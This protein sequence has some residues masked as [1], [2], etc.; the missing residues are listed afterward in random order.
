[1]KFKNKF[2]YVFV[3]AFLKKIYFSEANSKLQINKSQLGERKTAV[4]KIKLQQHIDL[5][6]FNVVIS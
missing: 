6:C 4:E 3:N 2:H 5:R 1:M